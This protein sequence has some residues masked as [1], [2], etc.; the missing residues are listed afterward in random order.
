M[1]RDNKKTRYMNKIFRYKVSQI[2]EQEYEVPAGCVVLTMKYKGAEPLPSVWI[3][4]DANETKTQK[5]KLYTV[6]TGIEF[7]LPV[8]AWYIGTY[9]SDDDVYVWHVYVYFEPVES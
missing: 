1:S 8:G 5:M 3:S 7:D 4:F 9:F 6:G 2:R